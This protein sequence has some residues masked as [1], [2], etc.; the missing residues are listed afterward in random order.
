[1][2][3]W[4][5]KQ[6]LLVLQRK[7][8]SEPRESV[9]GAKGRLQRS[10]VV[11]DVAQIGLQRSRK[12]VACGLSGGSH[13]AQAEIGCHCIPLIVS[14]AD[15]CVYGQSRNPVMEAAARF[16]ARLLIAQGYESHASTYTTSCG[17]AKSLCDSRR[18]GQLVCS[19]L[20]QS[21]GKLGEDRQVGVESDAFSA[22]DAERQE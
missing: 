9:E 18:Y 10:A 1:V 15:C 2:N 14:H 22:A 19:L 20:R 3:R 16:A 4:R 11:I 7:K 6:P 12:V 5:E 21:A 17:F 8:H 13:P